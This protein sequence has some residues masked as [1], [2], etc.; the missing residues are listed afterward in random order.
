MRRRVTGRE[1]ALAAAALAKLP[2]VGL[3]SMDG[4][5]DGQKDHNNSQYANHRKLVGFKL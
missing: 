3:A 5:D 2:Q 4:Q 1:P